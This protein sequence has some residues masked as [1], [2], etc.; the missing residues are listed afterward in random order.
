MSTPTLGYTIRFASSNMV[1]VK[2]L[3]QWAK[4]K[5]T[6]LDKRVEIYEDPITGLSF[7]ALD[8]IPPGSKLG[9]SSP[10]TAL[11]YL[12]AI[13]GLGFSRYNSPSFPKEFITDLK[14]K[15]HIIGNFFLVQQYLM[16]KES[17]WWYYIR[18]L[19]QPDQPESM[20]T[21]MWWSNEDISYLAD[22]NAD[23]AVKKKNALWMS[24]YKEGFDLLKSCGHRNVKEFT[25][26]LYKWAA[27]IF[28][29]RSFRP[30]L[31]V[32]WPGL[33]ELYSSTTTTT[34]SLDSAIALRHV[35][36]D[37]FSVLLPVLD[38][39]NHNGENH[40]RWSVDPGGLFHL[41]TTVQVE[42]GHQIYNFYG[43]KSNSELLVGYGFILPKEEA[44][45][46]NLKV[47]PPP[48]GL[49]LRRSQHCYEILPPDHQSDQEWMYSIHMFNKRGISEGLST[50][51]F[52]SHGL[53][54]TM[55]CLVANEREKEFLSRRPEYCVEKDPNVFCGEMARNIID[56]L[57]GLYDKLNHDFEKLQRGDK[58]LA[59]IS[60]GSTRN[61]NKELALDYR[62]R[63]SRVYEN[64]MLPIR[65]L[66][67]ALF[68]YNT[69]CEHPHHSVSQGTTNEALTSLHASVEILSLECAYD[70][71][72]RTSPEVYG[73][74]STFVS[75]LE[76]EPDPPNW[77]VLAKDFGYVYWTV[78]VF[79]VAMLQKGTEDKQVN[80]Y[81]PD[82][83]Q[84]LLRMHCSFLKSLDTQDSLRPRYGDTQE[85]ETIQEVINFIPSIPM[86]SSTCMDEKRRDSYQSFA[87]WVAFEE[88]IVTK[89]VETI[90]D[91]YATMPKQPVLCIKK[92]LMEP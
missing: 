10:T 20:P 4:I 28:G 59:L 60:L 9:I 63:Q 29:T 68:Q 52:F 78:W 62:S 43:D 6:T 33:S 64:A 38:I 34:Y 41:A 74:L 40:V 16:G 87:I 24:D 21:P 56:V 49:S 42:K 48:S 86:L 88:T 73:P 39:G 77:G 5:G 83:E 30:S 53:I 57:C 55:S 50:F 75:K 67:Q 80:W 13:G 18:T 27:T 51:Q 66:L 19:P 65:L 79:I 12:N 69:F 25:Y 15:P 26:N 70:W 35:S 61:S 1:M 91:D 17:V 54:D 22:T 3:V 14:N 44:D 82:L 81:H 45:I 36:A 71:L 76:D 8:T 31:T 85:R 46:A 90:T 92:M 32:S 37:Q 11:S 89:V 84:W 7:R 23:V 2:E 47:Q 72:R 58:S